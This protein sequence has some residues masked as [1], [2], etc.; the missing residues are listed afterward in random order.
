MYGIDHFN[1]IVVPPQAAILAIGQL[2]QR[3]VPINGIP[4]VRT[5]VTLT[6][7]CDHRVVD[8]VRAAQFLQTVAALIADPLALLD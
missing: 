6:L 1:A 8:G 3:C 4:A 2:N 5:M 7:S